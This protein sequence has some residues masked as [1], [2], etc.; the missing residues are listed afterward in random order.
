MIEKIKISVIIP[1]YGVEQYLAE[2]IDSVISQDYKNIE[3]ILVDDE[4]PDK[5]PEICDEYAAQFENIK[6]IHKKN[7]GLSEARNSGVEVSTGDYIIFLDGD[8]FWDDDEAISR[9]VKRIALTNVDVLNYSYMKYFEDTG[10]KNPYFS[11]QPEMP[12]DFFSKEE[13]LEYL[14]GKGLYIASACN[15][16]IK[17]S[18]FNKELLFRKGVYSEDIEWCAR[19]L[20]NVKSMDFICENFYCYRQRRSS[21][22]HTINDQK[23]LD[24]CN[25]II[26]CFKLC[27]K[28][29]KN[30]QKFL[31][32]FIA[33]QYG[34]FFKVQAQAKNE[35]DLVVDRLKE[36]KWILKYNCGN[37]KLVLLNICCKIFGY[38]R[39]CK[40]SRFIYRK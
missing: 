7:G 12:S 27:D 37:K 13:Q 1:V 21:I 33:Y 15:K 18:L 14:T 30:I 16:V 9:I 34:T 31:Y 6:V 17:R 20:V 32:R 5:S 10:V 23:C 4:S 22:T 3:I 2:C 38:Q 26:K 24:L 35:Q 39:T 8:D 40:M 28:V 11:N 29:D 25:N 19:L 36:Y